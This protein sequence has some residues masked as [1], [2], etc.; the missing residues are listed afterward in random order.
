MRERESVC[1][2]ECVAK[3]YHL[4]AEYNEEMIFSKGANFYVSADK[5][6]RKINPKFSHK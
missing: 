4:K 5:T 6:S 2:C 3:L 1:V